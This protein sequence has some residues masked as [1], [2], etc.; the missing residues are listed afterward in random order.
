MLIAILGPC[1]VDGPAMTTSIAIELKKITDRHPD[2]GFIFKA[3]LDKANRTSH[4]SFRGLGT[5]YALEIISSIRQ[6]V[7]IPVLT[8]VHSVQD[9]EKV[10]QHVDYIQIPAFLGRQTDLLLAAAETQ[11]PI[12][13]K[14]PQ[15]CAPHDVKYIVEKI[16]SKSDA[17][18]LVTERGHC[19]G[20]NDLVVDFRGFSDLETLGVSVI[21]DMSHSL[22]RPSAHGTSGSTPDA[23][24]IAPRMA[25]AA[26]AYGIDGIFAECYPNPTKARCDGDTSLYL[27]Q[28]DPLLTDLTTIQ[29]CGNLKRGGQN[30]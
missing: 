22:Q 14:K 7:K 3:S 24:N 12:N 18:L 30:P 21:F 26:V 13:I 4:K 5:D 27:S 10:A 20:Y 19:F 11:L 8:D 23:R 15:F 6:E 29:S 17:A 16:R 9:V 25:R 1:I 28:V 2:V